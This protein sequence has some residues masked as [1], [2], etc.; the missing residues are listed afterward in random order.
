[1]LPRAGCI[2][3]PPLVL[4]IGPLT[5]V[6]DVRLSGVEVCV[7]APRCVLFDLLV[8]FLGRPATMRAR[9]PKRV[10]AAYN[11]LFIFGVLVLLSGCTL[12]VFAFGWYSLGE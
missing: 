8:G 5:A 3:A 1:M 12:L 11:A 2:R 7:C 4:D 9:T 10:I 6:F